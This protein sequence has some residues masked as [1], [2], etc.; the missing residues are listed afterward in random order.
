MLFPENLK[1]EQD[2]SSVI[3]DNPVDAIKLQ[4]LR[5]QLTPGDTLLQREKVDNYAEATSNLTSATGFRVETRAN[6]RHAAG[7]AAAAAARCS[8]LCRPSAIPP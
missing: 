2:D 4:R 3:R 8:R 1:Q 7:T 5:S 6:A